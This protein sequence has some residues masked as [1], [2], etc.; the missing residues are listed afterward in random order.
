MDFY[1][2]ESINYY[3]N[4]FVQR[5][6]VNNIP[7]KFI[8][9]STAPPYL[10]GLPN[11][12]SNGVLDMYPIEMVGHNPQAQKG[13]AATLRKFMN[14]SVVGHTPGYTGL[15][16]DASLFWSTFKLMQ[17]IPKL[18]EFRNETFLILGYSF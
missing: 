13:L 3:D 1:S 7:P 5:H 14:I 18:L 4:S 16:M 6:H 2:K 11:I 17:S 8:P 9:S 10:S 12:Y 15:L